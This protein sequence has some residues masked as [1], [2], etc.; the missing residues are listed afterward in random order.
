M[1]EEVEV[2]TRQIY[3]IPTEGPDGMQ[4]TEVAFVTFLSRAIIGAIVFR[5]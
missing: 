4:N 5:L 3:L 2:E 1:T